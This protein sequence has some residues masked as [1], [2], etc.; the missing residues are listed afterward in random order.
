MPSGVVAL[1][2]CEWLVQERDEFGVEGGAY[3]FAAQD[4]EA[5]TEQYQE[6]RRAC[7]EKGKAVHKNVMSAWERADR[8]YRQLRERKA[9]VIKDRDTIR[10]VQ[11]AVHG[12]QLCCEAVVWA[13]SL[14]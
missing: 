9:T 14:W 13:C 4:M 1:Q 2:A 10:Q 5:M 8:D 11:P 12:R 6:A 7:D 3:D